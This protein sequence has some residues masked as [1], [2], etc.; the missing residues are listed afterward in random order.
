MDDEL[1][2]AGYFFGGALCR[3]FVSKHDLSPTVTGDRTR[4]PER[5]KAKK[6]ISKEKRIKGRPSS[7]F[8]GVVNEHNGARF[9]SLSCIIMYFPVTFAP[10]VDF[11]FNGANLERAACG[12]IGEFAETY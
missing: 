9:S 5:Q 7:F 6:I 2:A 10:R 8:P 3:P 12:G 4:R 11:N 1:N